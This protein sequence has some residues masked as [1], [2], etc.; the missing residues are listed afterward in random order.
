[1]DDFFSFSFLYFGNWVL[2]YY[3][4]YFYIFTIKLAA[5]W[6]FS[7]GTRVSSTNKTD[8]HDMTEI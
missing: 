8:H 5:G 4:I 3:H 1:M 6:W 7:Q 2:T